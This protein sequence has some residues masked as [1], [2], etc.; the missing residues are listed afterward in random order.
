MDLGSTN[1]MVLLPFDSHN[2]IHMGPSTDPVLLIDQQKLCGMAVQSTSPMDYETVIGLSSIGR[3]ANMVIIPCLGV[4]P[5]WLHTLSE[6]D[7]I[8]AGDQEPQWV[9]ELRCAI[10]DGPRNI[11][12]GETGLDGFHF[13]PSTKA[14]TSPMVRQME[15]FHW[16]LE[17]AFGLDKPVSVHCVQAFGPLLETFSTLKKKKKL[18]KKIYFHAFGGKEGTI[19]QLTALCD[20][21]YFGFAPVVNFRSPKTASVIRKVGIERLVLETDH[22]D[23]ALVHDSM[24]QGITFICD[25]LQLGRQDVI[26]RTSRNAEDLYGIA[27]R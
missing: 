24:E 22:E 27:L 6:E 9:H 16:H 2:H 15:A 26:K 23:A 11:A 17:L 10:R 25:A 14:L 3:S 21:V 7:W 12:I 13:D 5:W 8:V 1:A 19:D 4:H 20:K 18:P